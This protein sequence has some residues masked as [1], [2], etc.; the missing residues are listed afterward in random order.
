MDKLLSRIKNI[1]NQRVPTHKILLVLTMIYFVVFGLL[2]VHTS[3]Q[4]DQAPH[5]YF[6]QQFSETWGIPEENLN[7]RYTTTGQPYLYYWLNGA[8]YKIFNLLFPAGRLRPI[9]LWRLLSVFYSTL[10]VFFTYKLAAKVTGN[11]Y[12]GVLTSFFLSNTLMFVFISGGV[13]YD[14]LINL[15]GI[16][17]IYHLVCVYKKESFIWHTALTGIWVI[18]GSLA[19]EQFLLLTLIIFLAWLYFVIRNMKKIH[20]AF[21]RK[22]III[23]IIF[24]IFLTLFL[25]LYGVNLIRYS[26]TTPACI[27]IKSAKTCRTYNYR[28]EYF[29]PFNLQWLW[30]VRDDVSNPI[31]YGVTYWVFKMIESIWGILSETSF[32]PML[33]VSLHGILIAWAFFCYFNQ[34]HDRDKMSMLLFIILFSYCTYVFL[35]NYKTEIEYNFQHFGVTGRY[36]LPVLSPLLTLMTYSFLR[37]RSILLRR[38]TISL[39]I[40]LYFAGGMG[41]YITRYAE[42]FFHWRIY[43]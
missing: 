30:F 21:Q 28:F 13:S 2:M 14:N 34:W 41:M 25:G 35:W 42:V 40:L 32:I 8:I 26:R 3:G 10:T 37:I 36:L 29:E 38:L 33:S 43:F 6:S 18:I 7:I 27:Q 11:P 15:A 19:K 9:F 39:S 1:N 12:A 17:A 31:Y 16:A 24:L 22:E 23:S 5:T 4:P 20:L